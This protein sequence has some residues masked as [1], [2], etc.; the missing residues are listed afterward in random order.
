MLEYSIEIIRSA[1]DYKKMNKKNYLYPQVYLIVLYTGSKK[2]TS[3]LEYKE[4][5]DKLLKSKGNGINAKYSLID[6]HNYT[7]EE[8]MKD[9]SILKNILAIGKCKNAKE[10]VE[11]LKYVISHVKTEEKRQNLIRIVKYILPKL[12][13]EENVDSLLKELKKEEINMFGMLEENLEKERQEIRKQAEMEGRLEGILQGKI[14]GKKE[15]RREG[16]IELIKNMIREKI[17]MET[18]IKIANCTKEEIDE[19]LIS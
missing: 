11:T 10:V 1:I 16:K 9:T 15:G 2:W 6:I 17:P 14:E 3:K 4:I 13:G 7:K 18:I 5:S 12:I 19:M 8:L